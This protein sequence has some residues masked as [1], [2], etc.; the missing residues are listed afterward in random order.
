[1]IEECISKFGG[2]KSTYESSTNERLICRLATY[3]N[4]PSYIALQNHRACFPQPEGVF[5]VRT[6]LLRQIVKSSFLPRLTAKGREFCKLGHDL[7]IPFARKLLQ[8]SKEGLTKFTMEKI[9]RVGLVGKRDHLYAKAS[10]D[11]IAGVII[12]GENLLVR[13][14]CKARV[15]PA[16]DQ[17]ERL[18]TE[19]ISHFH[20]MSLASSMASTSPASTSTTTSSTTFGIRGAELYTIIEAASVDFNAYVDSSH[21]AVQLLHQAYVCS[22]K[23]VLLLVGDRSG[24][25]IR[26][27][28]CTKEECSYCKQFV[29]LTA[30]F[31]FLLL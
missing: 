19:F 23:Y 16:T 20:S 31:T 29:L 21:K 8:Q 30:F 7:E 28:F 2:K 27:M 13:V 26:G 6:S 12:K 18:H 9:Y 25:I 22:F 24:N 5:L 1:L 10:C 17:R 11:F 15:T 14:E 3:Q 4:D